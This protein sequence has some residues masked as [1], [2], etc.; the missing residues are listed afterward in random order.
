MRKNAFYKIPYMMLALLFLGGQAIADENICDPYEGS[1]YGLCTAYCE[2]MDCDSEE[3]QANKKACDVVYLRF[4]KMTGNPPPCKVD[5]CP[6]WDSGELERMW[7]TYD[8]MCVIDD[9]NLD[10]EHSKTWGLWGDA[11]VNDDD[12]YVWAHIQFYPTRKAVWGQ[13]K[14]GMVLN[15]KEWPLNFVEYRACV[16]RLKEHAAPAGFDLC[17]P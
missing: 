1:A 12:N 7:D 2:A 8:S 5:A 11:A 17:N 16:E 9:Q 13:A 3:H 10:L 15:Q 14:D 4:E 6:A